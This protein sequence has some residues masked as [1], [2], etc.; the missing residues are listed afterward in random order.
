M[1]REH[2]LWSENTSL[3]YEP[4][5]CALAPGYAQV[6]KETYHKAKETYYKAKEIYHKAKETYYKAKETYHKA[7]ETYYKAKETYYCPSAP[8][9]SSSKGTHSAVREH[10]L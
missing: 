7:K 5:C 3:P 6:S 9:R 1:V 8:A 2:I 10:I 4:L